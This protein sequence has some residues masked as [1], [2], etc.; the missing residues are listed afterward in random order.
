MKQCFDRVIPTLVS[1]MQKQ[2]NSQ[3]MYKIV[4]ED[5]T[6]LCGSQFGRPESMV[7]HHHQGP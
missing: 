5:S 4:I 7:K 6:L 1:G 3:Q 2:S